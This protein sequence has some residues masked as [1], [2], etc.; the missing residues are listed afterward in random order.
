MRRV[1]RLPFGRT[2]IAREVDDEL[3]FHLEMR[4]QRLVASGMTPEAAQHEAL[5]Q[6]GNVDSVRQ[7]CVIMDEQRERAMSRADLF[8]EL[9]QNTVYALRTLRRN[10]G[11]TAVVVC[12]L[13]LGIGANTAIFTLI[14]AVVVRGLPVSHPEQL[15]AV[16]DTRLVGSL[17]QGSPRT[18]LLSYP[19]YKDIRANPA[20]FTGVLASGRAGRMDIHIDGS[21]GAAEH[22][23]SRF[24][25]DNYFSVLGVPALIGRVFTG[26]E[27]QVPGSA[28]VAT[29]SYGYWTQR[30]HNDSSVIGKTI[31][32]N[33]TRIVII[34][35][36]P[37]TFSGDIVG[38]TTD[39]WLPISMHDVLNPNAR[40]LTDRSSSWLL[41]LGRAAPGRTLAQTKARLMPFIVRDIVSN[42]PGTTG[43][44]FAASDPKPFIS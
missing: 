32:I 22:P 40:L 41:L 20:F 39:I 21:A 16:G 38:T 1:F 7:D 12:A 43:Q 6:F 26:T 18:D 28:P 9:R 33:D 8:G 44:A 23:R 17:S 36:G 30:F 37:A 13:A 19:L 35:V 11:F 24:V 3:A 34:G 31:L 15:I 29:I 4:M 42:A 27:D 10:P 25:S 14:D 5:R 2:S